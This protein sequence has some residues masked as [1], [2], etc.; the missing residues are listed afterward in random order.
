MAKW[1]IT[2]NSR[3]RKNQRTIGWRNTG[4]TG[5]LAW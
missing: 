3:D 1:A 5:S 2:W 4:P